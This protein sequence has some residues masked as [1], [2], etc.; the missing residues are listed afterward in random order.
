MS[1]KSYGKYADFLSLRAA[2]EKQLHKHLFAGKKSEATKRYRFE[3]CL[4][5]A[6]IGKQVAEHSGLDPELLELGCLLH[7][8]GKWDAQKPVD[9]GRAGAL[10][11]RELLLA[12]GLDKSD[13]R[14]IA[15]GIA[16]HTDGYWNPR[17]DGE[18]TKKDAQRRSY[19]VFDQAPSVL[20]QSIGDCDNID[21]YSVYRIVDTVAH[22]DFLKLSSGEQKVWLSDYLVTLKELRRYRCATE[23]A[24]SL[25]I[26]NLAFQEQ[27]FKKLLSEVEA[28]TQRG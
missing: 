5:V 9:H 2:L 7:D 26:S 3:H 22:F 21:R 23:A 20:A 4:R 28:G 15:Q 25:W 18:G 14:E 8:I 12:A 27:C 6:A 16:M 1:V 17:P 10:A 24:Q 19:L 13:V 11:V